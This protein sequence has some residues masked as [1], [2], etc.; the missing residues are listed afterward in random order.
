VPREE[1]YF[2]GKPD[3]RL[4]PSFVV[5]VLDGAGAKHMSLYGSDAKRRR[6]SKLSVTK[7]SSSTP[8]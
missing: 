4:R 2:A 7:A 3:L 5:L 1:R 6:F 8:P